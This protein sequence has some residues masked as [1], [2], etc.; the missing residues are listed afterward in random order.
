MADEAS[1]NPQIYS[2]AWFL[3]LVLCLI[4][5]FFGEA[6]FLWLDVALIMS[7][8]IPGAFSL[9]YTDFEQ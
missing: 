5:Y 2:S 3:F 9:W 8:R 6:Q 4:D 7:S 1:V